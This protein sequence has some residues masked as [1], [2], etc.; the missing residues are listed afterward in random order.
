M[1]SSHDICTFCTPVDYND[2]RFVEV[3]FWE[4]I[5]LGIGMVLMG[6]IKLNKLLSYWAFIETEQSYFTKHF[7][8]MKV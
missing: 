3:Y 8:K 2:I 4:I 7:R 5:C 6:N 1:T